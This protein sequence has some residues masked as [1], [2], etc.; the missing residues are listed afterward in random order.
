MQLSFR[1][2]TTPQRP[3]RLLLTCRPT[4]RFWCL[5]PKGRGSEYVRSR[6]SV[7]DGLDSFGLSC[8]ILRAFMF[9]FMHCIIYMWW[10]DLCDMC[11]LYFDLYI[12]HATSLCS[13]GLLPC[14]TSIQMSFISCTHA[15]FISIEYIMIGLGHIS[16][17][18]S[19]VLIVKSLYEPSMLKTSS[20]LHTRGCIVINHQK[21]GDWKHLGP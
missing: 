17:P 5:T 7:W 3:T 11:A 6:G 2:L 12:C 18:Y 14:F 9:T 21:G 10:W 13:F 16:L 19:F 20:L 15:Y 8:V 1:S 4:L